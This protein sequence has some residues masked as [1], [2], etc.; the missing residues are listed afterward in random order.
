MWN[1]YLNISGCYLHKMLVLYSPD[2]G[3]CLHLQQ[4]TPMFQNI[5]RKGLQK[6][7]V[8]YQTITKIIV[9]NYLFIVLESQC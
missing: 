5:I 2:T 6:T 3:H 1:Y 7:V 8:S 4:I 9:L